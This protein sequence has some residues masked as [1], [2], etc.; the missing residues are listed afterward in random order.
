V[1]VES[2]RGSIKIQARVTDAVDPRVVFITYGWGQA[3]AHG[4][5]A[6]VLTPDD[7]VCPVS[8]AT[9]SRSF[10]CRVRKS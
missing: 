1:T 4:A 3:Y 10:L 5:N 2:P 9:G 6:N 7:S 8:G